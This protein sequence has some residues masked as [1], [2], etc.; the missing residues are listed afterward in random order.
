MTQKA[1]SFLREGAAT[2]MG[3]IKAIATKPAK[4]PE[5]LSRMFPASPRYGSP[6]R[7]PP[8]LS[9]KTVDQNAAMPIGGPLLSTCDTSLHS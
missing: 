7:E 6:S 5:E 3:S 4:A 8:Y 2:A 9:G 1:A